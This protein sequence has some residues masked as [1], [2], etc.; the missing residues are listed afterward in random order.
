MVSFWFLPS[1]CEAVF[2]HEEGQGVPIKG[3]L[4]RL[5]SISLDPLTFFWLLL[6]VV[7]GVRVAPTP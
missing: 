2:N 4:Q 3:L 5:F 6:L 1:N 7:R